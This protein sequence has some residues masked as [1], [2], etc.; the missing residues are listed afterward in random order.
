MQNVIEI[1]SNEALVFDKTDADFIFYSI[2]YYI[3]LSLRQNPNSSN[4]EI[5]SFENLLLAVNNPILH[6]EVN[7]RND[8]FNISH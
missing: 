5:E 8:F 7:S 6:T 1:I 2:Y 4:N 3:V